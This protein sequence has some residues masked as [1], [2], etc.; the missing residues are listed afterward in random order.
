MTNKSNY[1]PKEINYVPKQINYIKKKYKYYMYKTLDWG[2]HGDDDDTD[3]ACLF[4]K[5]HSSHHI[6]GTE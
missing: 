1:L 5:K 4:I 2:R 6:Y 3:K